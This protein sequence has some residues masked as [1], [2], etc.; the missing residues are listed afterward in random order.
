MAVGNDLVAEGIAHAAQRLMHE[1]ACEEVPGSLTVTV[2]P[3]EE[4]DGTTGS[5]KAPTQKVDVAF[6][7]TRKGPFFVAQELEVQTSSRGLAGLG[8][9][10]SRYP[11]D[12]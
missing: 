7:C 6:K 4:P 5:L 11:S 10:P 12:K 2:G 1:H 3:A 9:Q 8:A